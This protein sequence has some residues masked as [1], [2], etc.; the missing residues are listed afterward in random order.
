MTA[1]SRATT[2]SR[3]PQ[4]AERNKFLTVFSISVF[5]KSTHTFL[6]NFRDLSGAFHHNFQV[7]GT[8]RKEPLFV[9]AESVFSFIKKLY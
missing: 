2:V 5:R 7:G 1:Y 9:S 8:W 6:M 4:G 3:G